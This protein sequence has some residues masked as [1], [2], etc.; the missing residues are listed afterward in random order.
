MATNTAFFAISF[1]SKL[2]MTFSNAVF[3][4]LSHGAIHFVRSVSFKNLEMEVSN[5]LLKNFNHSEQNGSHQV[6]EHGVPENETV[7]V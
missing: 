6:K 7:T 3:Y 1:S 4:A 2:V 5:W